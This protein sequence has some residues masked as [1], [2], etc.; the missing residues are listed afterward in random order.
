MT[1]SFSCIFKINVLRNIQVNYQYIEYTLIHLN[2]RFRNYYVDKNG[3]KR[4]EIDV[5]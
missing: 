2:Q 4:I 3:W 1:G 5:T